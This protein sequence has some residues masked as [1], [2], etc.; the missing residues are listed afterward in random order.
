M[1]VLSISNAKVIEKRLFKEL[2]TEL[3]DNKY[4]KSWKFVVSLII[5]I[6]NK[7]LEFV[8]FVFTYKVYYTVEDEKE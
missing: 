6:T 7:E 1:M 3:I 2:F 5:V 8:K 4:I